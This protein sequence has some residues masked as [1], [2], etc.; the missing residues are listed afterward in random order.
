MNLDNSIIATEVTIDP[1]RYACNLSILWQD[2]RL[3]SQAS[4]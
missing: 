3:R 1:S 4:H 2:F